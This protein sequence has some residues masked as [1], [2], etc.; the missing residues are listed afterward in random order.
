[1]P[2]IDVEHAGSS[3]PN[4]NSELGRAM[5]RH[6]DYSNFLIE[7]ALT[8]DKQ[9]QLK[10]D[11]N[12]NFLDHINVNDEE[13]DKDGYYNSNNNLMECISSNNTK[14]GCLPFVTVIHREEGSGRHLVNERDIIDQARQMCSGNTNDDLYSSPNT[15]NDG[16]CRD[17]KIK[18]SDRWR[19][20]QQCKVIRVDLGRMSLGEQA[21]I[22]Q[23]TSI[24]IGVLGSGLHNSIFMRS[25]NKAMIMFAPNDWCNYVTHVG[26]EAIT[27]DLHVMIACQERNKDEMYN[28]QWHTMAWSA[29][30]WRQGPWR[31]KDVPVEVDLEVFKTLLSKA[32]NLSLSPSPS[33]SSHFVPSHHIIVTEVPDHMIIY[34]LLPPPPMLLNSDDGKS[35]SSNSTTHQPIPIPLFNNHFLHFDSGRAIACLSY[36]YWGV[37]M[38]I[39]QVKGE[40][41]EGLQLSLQAYVLLDSIPSESLDHVHFCLEAG[42]GSDLAVSCWPHTKLSERSPLIITISRPDRRFLLHTW[43]TVHNGHGRER[44]KWPG[45]DNYYV[46]NGSNQNERKREE[47]SFFS[48]GG[49]FRPVLGLPSLPK[50]RIQ[51]NIRNWLRT[52]K[53]Q[54][55]DDVLDSNASCLCDFESM[56][57]GIIHQPVFKF[58]I[59]I[60]EPES[61]DENLKRLREWE[62]YSKNFP[63]A[64]GMTVSPLNSISM[65]ENRSACLKKEG[66][67]PPHLP[68]YIMANAC[69]TESIEIAKNEACLSVMTIITSHEL[70]TKVCKAISLELMS[71]AAV[72]LEAHQIGLPSQQL[73]PT[74]Q[75][76]FIFFHL[77]KCGGSSVRSILAS[78]ASRRRLHALI[79]CYTSPPAEEEEL[80]TA[81]ATDSHSFFSYTYNP[82]DKECLQ[83]NLNQL[84]LSAQKKISVLA[85]HHVNG[86]HSWQDLPSISNKQ[87]AG[88]VGAAA[89]PFDC[90][91]M[92]RNPIERAISLFS[93]RIR[94]INTQTGVEISLNS[95]SVADLTAIIRSESDGIGKRRPNHDSGFDVDDIFV[96]AGMS[97]AACKM[98]CGA[99]RLHGRRVSDPVPSTLPYDLNTAKDHLSKY[100]RYG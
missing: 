51:Q 93:T 63:L 47:V 12:E 53:Q 87:E 80:A 35:S 2:W 95:L 78:S 92:L 88:G 81:T 56:A 49:C 82:S 34:R 6:A 52:T 100:V 99:T 77:E 70:G 91:V 17:S 24:L 19:R 21:S 11:T 33:S 85:M 57:S 20:R 59:L 58:G 69:S 89:M 79:P 26:N 5:K 54:Q 65:V 25:D 28:K 45:S 67:Q 23:S 32:M 84:S 98:L 1:M 43:L 90:F 27:N 61:D 60:D 71:R 15:T 41:G 16:W 55:Y 9:Q 38:P 74:P 22:L 46:W 76:P 7:A 94:V 44:K 86:F 4:A 40:G 10:K 13:G 83:F 42:E 48:G 31:T 8:L 73:W 37:A 97:D 72:E 64:T 66:K 50:H 3:M 68:R 75:R 62:E 36:P 14:P 39:Q 18:S 96:D 30:A 29:R